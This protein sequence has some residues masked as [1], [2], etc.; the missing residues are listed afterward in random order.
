MFF[1][2]QFLCLSNFVSF[3]FLFLFFWLCFFGIFSSALFVFYILLQCRRSNWYT[4]R[5]R[6]SIIDRSYCTAL[7][8]NNCEV[9]QE[10]ITRSE[11]LPCA[12][13][14]AFSRTSLFLERFLAR[15][16]NI[17]KFHKPVSKTYRPL[18]SLFD[19]LYFKCAHSHGRDSLFAGKSA[20][21]CV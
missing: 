12:R 13:A 16:L 20:L 8:H 6:P 17:F 14:T 4:C 21:K 7:G 10:P 2:F 11:Q 18:F 1:T 19:I 3:C 5:P 9:G 15:I